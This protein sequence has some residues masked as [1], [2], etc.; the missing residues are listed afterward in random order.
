[1]QILNS[2]RGALDDFP[3]PS[4]LMGNHLATVLVGWCGDCSSDKRQGAAGLCRTRL[5]ADPIADYISQRPRPVALT[6]IFCKCME[7]GRESG[8]TPVCMYGKRRS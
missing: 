3:H 8:P 5:T 1:M 2:L 7:R 6:S 4:A